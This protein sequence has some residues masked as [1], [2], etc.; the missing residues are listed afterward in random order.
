MRIL[1]TNDDGIGAPGIR[2]LA[3][4]AASLGEVWVVAPE[5]QCSA[6]SHRITIRGQM[7][8]RRVDFPVPASP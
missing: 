5:N 6:M 4:M 1:I 8:A 3:E 7:T 2:R